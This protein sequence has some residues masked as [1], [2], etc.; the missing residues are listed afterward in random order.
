MVLPFTKD[1]KLPPIDLD[2]GDVILAIDGVEVEGPGHVMALL[3]NK[4]PGS[5]VQVRVFRDRSQQQGDQ[6]MVIFLG[7]P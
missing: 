1:P 3:A 6:P 7:R 4:A 2:P 5:T